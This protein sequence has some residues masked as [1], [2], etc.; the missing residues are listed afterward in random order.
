MM[1]EAPRRDRL[2]RVSTGIK[3]GS[4]ADMRNGLTRMEYEIL[5]QGMPYQRINPELKRNQ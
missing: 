1:L 5:M 3:A 2:D 4:P